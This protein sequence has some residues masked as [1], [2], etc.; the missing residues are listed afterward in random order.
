MTEEQKEGNRLAADHISV[1]FRAVNLATNA[2]A[3]L[4]EAWGALDATQLG[5]LCRMEHERWAAPLWMAGWVAG[6]RD[7]ALRKHPN[8]VPY[9]ELDEGTRNYDLE[10]VRMSAAY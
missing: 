4:Q 6:E 1:K 2:G 3:A 7:D 5:M 8:L 10:Q 9:D